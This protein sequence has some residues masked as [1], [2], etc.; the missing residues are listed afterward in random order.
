MI[1]LEP[2]AWCQSLFFFTIIELLLFVIYTFRAAIPIICVTRSS[3]IIIRLEHL[4]WCP[5]PFLFASI[6]HQLHVVYALPAMHRVLLLLFP[7]LLYCIRLEP[8]LWRVIL[9][10]SREESVAI[11]YNFSFML[12]RFLFLI[13]N[14]FFPH[15]FKTRLLILASVSFL[16]GS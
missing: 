13:R 2:L 12:Y 15:K 14:S 9:L 3:F 10:V 1:R 7:D 6:G 4:S 8:C 11:V 16:S 5:S